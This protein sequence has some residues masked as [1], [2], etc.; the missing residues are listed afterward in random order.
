MPLFGDHLTSYSMG[1]W[2]SFASVV[3]ERRG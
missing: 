3:E 2:G 1:R